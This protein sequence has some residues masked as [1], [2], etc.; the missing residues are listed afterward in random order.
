MGGGAGGGGEGGAIGGI[1]GGMAGGSGSTVNAFGIYMS[2]KLPDAS[3]YLL[4]E[5]QL[6]PCPSSVVAFFS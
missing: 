6:P 4:T 3:V 2:K 5:N 1:G